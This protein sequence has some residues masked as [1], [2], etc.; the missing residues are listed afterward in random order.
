M[1]AARKRKSNPVSILKRAAARAFA[2]G[3]CPL[4][5]L[6]LGLCE[7]AGDAADAVAAV[8]ISF[9]FSKQSWEHNKLDLKEAKI[10]SAG[11]FGAK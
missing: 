1:L 2:F 4:V 10:R 9:F 6:E 5:D 11:R 3:H 7:R 8:V